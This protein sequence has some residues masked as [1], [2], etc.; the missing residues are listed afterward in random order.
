MKTNLKKMLVGVLLVV[1]GLQAMAIDVNFKLSLKQPGNDA[2]TYPLTP[3][4]NQLTASKA[5]PLNISYQLTPQDDNLLLTV[6]LTAK[7]RVYFNIGGSV[8]T[9]YQTD[10]CEF[11]L[12]GFWYHKT[13]RSPKEL[14]LP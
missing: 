1:G 9:N 12:P 10:D 13:L 7:E 8:S 11:Y 3:K 5:L 4:G 2:V 14:E 6:T